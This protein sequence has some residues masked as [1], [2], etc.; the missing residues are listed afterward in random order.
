MIHSRE[1]F[2]CFRKYIIC[3]FMCLASQQKK[4][5]G[6]THHHVHCSFQLSLELESFYLPIMK[7][8]GFICNS[9]LQGSLFYKQVFFK[10][11][12]I[13]VLAHACS[14]NGDTISLADIKPQPPP[15]LT[16]SKGRIQIPQTTKQFVVSWKANLLEQQTKALTSLRHIVQ[17][18]G[19]DQGTTKETQRSR[20]HTR[21]WIR[22]S[23]R[24]LPLHSC[25]LEPWTVG[26]QYKLKELGAL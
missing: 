23:A 21:L 14:I 13:S 15:D 10:V 25:Y 20:R 5:L 1:R 3:P 17:D 11:I 24:N 4:P 18:P 6:V 7:L 19:T 26:L 12:L 2:S 9:A 22:P 8:F 16:R